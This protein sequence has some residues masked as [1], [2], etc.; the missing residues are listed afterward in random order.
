MSRPNFFF[1]SVSARSTRITPQRVGAA[2]NPS[3]KLRRAGEQQI[4]G[5]GWVATRTSIGF[6]QYSS[7]VERGQSGSRT[8]PRKK[9]IRRS[10]CWG[11]V[12]TG[13]IEVGTKD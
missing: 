12:V 6:E 5:A 10:I 4:E 13:I 9:D 2:R 7:P 1:L 3:V 11:R 8:G